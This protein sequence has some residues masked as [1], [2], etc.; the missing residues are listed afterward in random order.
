MALGRYA[1]LVVRDTGQGMDRDTKARLFEPFF[2]TK[3]SGRG[4]GLGLSTV[5][6]I[7]KQNGGYI[8]V[9]SEP[10]AGTTF[11]LYFPR[12]AVTEIAPAPAARAPRQTTG[13]SERI[14]VV[15]DDPGVRQFVA[16]V[17]ASRGY[18]VLP[19]S[20]ADEA[21]ALANQ[22]ESSIDLLLTDVVMPGSTGRALAT[23]L[24]Q[25]RPDLKVLYMSGYTTEAIVDHSILDPSVAFIGKPFTAE[26][27]AAKVRETLDGSGPGGVSAS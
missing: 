6:G 14:L 24:C 26:H 16:R 1:M 25:S 27:L 10:A 15:E 11:R 13:G 19:V 23:N 21:V 5:Y 17:L 4:T 7:V 18:L 8:F 3:D 12:R 22:Q 9:D 20:S 2:T